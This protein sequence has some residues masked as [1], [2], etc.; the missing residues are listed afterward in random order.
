MEF[1]ESLRR[2]PGLTA[3][4]VA[5]VLAGRR[6]GAS[7]QLD[8]TYL[9]GYASVLDAIGRDPGGYR[10]RLRES[11]EALGR[12]VE[13]TGARV[14][15]I[16]ESPL[17]EASRALAESAADL[18]VVES[19]ESAFP[20]R[21]VPVA[22]WN[23]TGET[24]DFGVRVYFFR[25]DDGPEG[26]TIEE[27][28]VSAVVADDRARFE[29][30]QGGLHGY[31]NCCVEAFQDRGA[32]APEREAVEAMAGHLSVDRLPGARAS[33]DAVLPDF[34]C[35]PDDDEY[36]WFAREFF[37]TPGCPTARERGREVYDALV[38]WFPRTLVRDYVRVNFLYGFAVAA[39]LDDPE[40]ARPRVEA[41]G[42][43]SVLLALPLRA[44]SSVDRYQ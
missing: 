20:G 25:P 19:F 23:R 42:R 27:R 32:L 21:V 37:P 28:N 26:R 34:F 15:A 5:P 11:R 10:E 17:L 39:R 38:E 4:E 44:L 7:V 24:L 18:P 35:D 16:E 30:Y 31:P 36:A 9:D 41:L 14:D 22:E 6:P 43:E 13:A 2:L 1:P 3:L 33:V 29:R 8:Y 12:A 40:A